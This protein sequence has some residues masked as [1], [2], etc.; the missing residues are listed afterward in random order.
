MKRVVSRRQLAQVAAAAVGVGLALTTGLTPAEAASSPWTVV[1]SADPGNNA[2]NRLGAVA[3]VN[4]NNV[5]AVGNSDGQSITENWNGTRWNVV[6]NP[7]PGTVV[8]QLNGVAASSAT[9]VWAVG[10]TSSATDGTTRTLVEHFD[11]SK[12]S[13]VSS[14]NLGTTDQL[15]SVAARSATD[16]W[17]VGR[18]GTKTLVEHWD[19]IRWSVV[20]SPNPA[21]GNNILSS[22]AIGSAT[23]VWVVG[24]GS[25][26]AGDGFLK[27]ALV[28]HFDGQTWQTVATPKVDA[29]SS[30]ALT[31]VAVGS[32]SDVW[33]VGHAG[34]GGVAEHWDGT[35]WSVVPTPSLG[36]VNLNGVTVLGTNDV[37]AV[38][39]FSTTGGSSNTLTEQWNGTSWSVVPSPTGT[40]SGQLKAVATAPT[41]TL[42]AVGTDVPDASTNLGRTFVLRNTTG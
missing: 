42:W 16:A 28:E 20:S 31:S 38:G 10:A 30:V 32:A 18:S 27:Q 33:A 36:V 15:N 40:V 35:A 11:G 4:A 25:V 5:W 21:P 8:D 34:A 13:V 2:F 23:D 26:V 9:D 1:P 3:V 22:V 17:A 7:H 29:T 14:P 6:S 39:D 37:W 12:W 41:N 19:G 24:T